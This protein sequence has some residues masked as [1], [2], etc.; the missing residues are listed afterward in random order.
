MIMSKFITDDTKDLLAKDFYDFCNEIISQVE[1]LRDIFNDSVY[2]NI[3]QES[4]NVI[5]NEYEA[6]SEFIGPIN[7]TRKFYPNDTYKDAINR[8]NSLDP[9]VIRKEI[10][11]YG[12]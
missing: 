10:E 4:I 9:E 1:G 12:D 3:V 8:L 11:R 6:Y 7:H 2:K 5:K